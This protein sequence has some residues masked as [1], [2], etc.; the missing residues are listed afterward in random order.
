MERM[1]FFTAFMRKNG[2]ALLAL[3]ALALA[4]IM[5]VALLVISS[6]DKKIEWYSDSLAELDAKVKAGEGAEKRIEKLTADVARLEDQK[7]AIED[8]NVTLAASVDELERLNGE[9]QK[10]L[11]GLSVPD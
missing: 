11:D 10:K 3:A 4:I 9:L 6:L 8:E 2:T 7:K 1:I 5:A